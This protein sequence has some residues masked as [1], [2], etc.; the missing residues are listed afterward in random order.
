MWVFQLL[1]FIFCHCL[2][3]KRASHSAIKK[4]KVNRLEESLEPLEQGTEGTDILV[5]AG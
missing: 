3:F 1:L 2:D 4:K 5:L